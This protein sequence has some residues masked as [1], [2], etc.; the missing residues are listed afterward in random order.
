MRGHALLLLATW[1]GIASAFEAVAV[2]GCPR[3]DGAVT[4]LSDTLRERVASRIAAPPDGRRA[5][6]GTV[7]R[8]LGGLHLRGGEELSPAMPKRKG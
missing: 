1:P 6:P 5:D 3:E 8:V 2:L 4:R 7:A